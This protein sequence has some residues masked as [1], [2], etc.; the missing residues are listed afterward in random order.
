MARRKKKDILPYEC[1]MYLSTYG[2]LFHADIREKR[3][4]RYIREYAK[5]HGI[6]IVGVMH[7]DALGMNDVDA[8][9]IKIA[10]LINK[11]KVD[12]VIVADMSCVSRDIVDAYSKV[13]LIHSVGGV[14]IT[15]DEGKL[16][17]ELKEKSDERI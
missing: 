14:I 9:F 4:E 13:G 2:D 11:K 12:G 3:Q 15:V 7:K 10:H 1:I 6:K 16:R 17:L 5:A 8:H